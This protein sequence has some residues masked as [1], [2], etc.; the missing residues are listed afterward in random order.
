MSRTIVR[1]AAVAAALVAVAGLSACSHGPAPA[2]PLRHYKTASSAGADT[3]QWSRYTFTIGDNGGDGSQELAD[4]TGVFKSAPYKVKFARFTFGPPLVQAAASGD[5]DLGLVGDVPPIT[6]AAKA[7]GFKIVGTAHY[8]DPKLATED[9]IVP[10]GSSIKTLADLKGKRIAIPQGSSAHGLALLALKSVGLTPKDVQISFLDPAAGASA[11]NSGKVDA[12]AIWNPQAALAV[13][14]GAKILV[15][16]LPPID[17]TSIYYVAPQKDLTDPN[18]KSALT[19]LFERLAAEFAWANHH[20]DDF[21]AAIAKEEG[22]SK[23]DARSVLNTFQYKFA[24]LTKQDVALEQ[25]L[26]SAFYDAGQIP[27]KVD[28][29]SITQN[30][31]PPGFDSTTL[32]VTG[33][34]S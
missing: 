24:P 7:Y 16:G 28:V 17:Q 5:I 20:P 8:L 2:A 4:I 32:D 27:K 15:A 12:W 23:A 9:I 18:R 30:L 3:S 13:K 25:Q 14:G 33:S 1:L 26:A 21:A 10:K 11:F 22:I 19:D 34:G 31:L 6:G 29:S